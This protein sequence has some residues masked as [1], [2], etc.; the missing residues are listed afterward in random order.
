[1]ENE[2]KRT[3]IPLDIYL[4][5]TKLPFKMTVGTMLEIAYWAQ[6]QPS[7]QAAENT[8]SKVLG[9]AVNDDTVRAVTN[10][11]GSIVFANDCKIAKEIYNK[12]ETGRLSFPQTPKNGILYIET[13]GAAVNTR[14]KDENGREESYRF[15]LHGART[16]R[17]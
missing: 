17:E 11:V 10:M 13:D 7:Y 15:F 4:G 9:I 1:M 3:I 6:N 2:G 12:L 16:N 14:L 5:I 8:I